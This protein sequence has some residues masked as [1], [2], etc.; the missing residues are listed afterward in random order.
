M[1]LDLVVDTFS[2]GTGIL[3]PTTMVTG[4]KLCLSFGT[5]NRG[6]LFYR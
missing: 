5:I 2:L 1:R 4:Y 6:V 3:T